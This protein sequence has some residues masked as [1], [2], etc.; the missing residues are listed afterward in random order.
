MMLSFVVAMDQNQL[1]GKNNQLPWRLPADLAFFKRVTMGSPI[2]MGRKT[3]ESI[4]RPLPG[5]KNII[6]TRSPD[7]HVD[8]CEVIHSMEEIKKLLKSSDD[9]LFLIGG[10]ELF[11]QLLH[12]ANKLYITYIDHEFGGDTYFPKFDLANWRLISEEKGPKDEKNPF[13]YY[14]RIYERI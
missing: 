6:L 8:G 7:F 1:I 12:E 5:R 10:S 13:D 14:F 9:E 3:Y 2:I 11:N 4:G